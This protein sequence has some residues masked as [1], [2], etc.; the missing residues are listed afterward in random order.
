MNNYKAEA[1]RTPEKQVE[2]EE[3]VTAELCEPDESENEEFDEANELE[4]MIQGNYFQFATEKKAGVKLDS[5]HKVLKGYSHQKS[6]ARFGISAF[7]N[8]NTILRAD[9]S[10]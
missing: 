3:D 8:E 1:F 10:N 9:N 5:G 7:K 4:D 6:K 2:Q